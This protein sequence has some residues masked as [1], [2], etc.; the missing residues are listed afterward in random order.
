MLWGQDVRVEFRGDTKHHWYNSYLRVL[1]GGDGHFYVLQTKSGGYWGFSQEGERNIRCLRFDPELKYAGDFKVESA[2]EVFKTREGIAFLT[3]RRVGN[4]EGSTLILDRG[5][6]KDGEMKWVQDSL[7]QLPSF[8]PGLAKPRFRTAWAADSSF[9]MLCWRQLP[10]EEGPDNPMAC[11]VLDSDLKVLHGVSTPLSHV[12]ADVGI[13]GM[14]LIDAENLFFHLK[15]FD[16]KGLF[17]TPQAVGSVVAHFDVVT[18]SLRPLYVGNGCLP[19]DAK[20]FEGEDGGI[21]VMG[22]YLGPPSEAR[23]VGLFRGRVTGADS[24]V[25]CQRFPFDASLRD[26]VILEQAKNGIGTTMRSMGQNALLKPD[27]GLVYVLHLRGRAVHPEGINLAGI[28]HNQ[29]L[30]A[31]TWDDSLRPEGFR[32]WG[33]KNEGRSDY[34]EAYAW[35]PLV[36]GGEAYA[37]CT[38]FSRVEKIAKPWEASTWMLPLVAETGKQKAYVAGA[39]APFTVLAPRHGVKLAEDAYLF[40]T[41]SDKWMRL[42]LLSL[43]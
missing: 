16:G 38:D 10:N 27:G 42:A 43:E 14:G 22:M 12:Q 2:Y 25:N 34:Q 3:T 9:M 40:L 41:R 5:E 26:E 28:D 23:E 17:Q 1:E 24:L 37:V 8:L 39:D 11:V 35:W 32:I 30:M 36:R 18:G 29:F 15:V 7:A 33:F 13:L 6:W 31:W 4:G 21:W 19:L 20:V